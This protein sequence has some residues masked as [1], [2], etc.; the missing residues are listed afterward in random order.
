MKMHR[1]KWY[2]SFLIPWKCAPVCTTL[3]I[4]LLFIRK[5]LPIVQIFA[6]T[7][8]IDGTIGLMNGESEGNILVIPIIM[9]GGIIIVEHLGTVVTNILQ[10]F[11]GNGIRAKFVDYLTVKCAKLSYAEIENCKTWDL[12]GR[13]KN[14]PDMKVEEGFAAL[15]N[16]MGI[17]IQTGS[18]LSVLF[19]KAWW[20]LP[21]VAIVGGVVVWFALRGGQ[22]QYNAE[23]SVAEYRRRYQYCGD[24]L[25]NRD[26]VEER[27]LFQFFSILQKM[28]KENYYKT[29]NAERKVVV[30]YLIRIKL[31][32]SSM[33]LVTFGIASLLLYPLA[34]GTLSVGLYISLIQ[35]AN[36]VIDLMSWELSD[37]VSAYV[38]YKE[39]VKDVVLFSNLEEVEGALDEPAKKKY[40]INEIQ[41]KNVSFTYPGTEKK[42]LDNINLKIEAGKHYAMVGGNGAGK[43]TIIKLLT[44]LYQNFEGEILINNISI[45]D[46]SMSEL[47]TMLAVLFQDFARYEISVEDNVALGDV[48]GMGTEK[49]RREIEEA[50]SMLGLSERIVGLGCGFNTR[51][52]KVLD[53]GE[54]LSGGEWQRLAMAR[55]VISPADLLV[56]DEPTAALDPLSESSLYEKFGK[57]SKGRT[58][59]FIS[60]RLGSTMLADE[61]IVLEQG[62]IIG[63]GDHETLISCCPLYRQMYESQRNWYIENA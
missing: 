42:I 20:S 22:N 61:I 28:W 36:G 39:Y 14:Q 32:S 40:K 47:K 38:K 10:H 1:Y 53:G 59:I 52:G 2:D 12:I 46:F 33:A 63:Q 55:A 15:L 44:G 4:L 9:L 11:I 41:F 49:Q 60:H 16:L 43:T 8:F 34:V 37:Y 6:T 26:A 24:L 57:I 62:E 17:F 56:L 27:S 19:F 35:A 13:I 18:F 5:G 21:F 45:S 51:L 31:V 29:R 25:T 48:C 30:N 3:Q 58:T 23:R 7:A 54:D 50:I